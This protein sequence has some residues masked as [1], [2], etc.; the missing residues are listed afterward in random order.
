VI[1]KFSH[2]SIRKQILLGFAPVLLVLG[3]LAYVSYHNGTVFS[4]DFN[5]F[6]KTSQDNVTVL[7]IRKDITEIQRNAL[8]YSY[9]GYAGVL[10]KIEYLQKRLEGKLEKIEHL[11]QHDP[12]IRD[13]LERMMVHY[14][15]YKGEFRGAIR[16]REEIRVLKEEQLK[17]HLKNAIRLLEKAERQHREKG[18]NETAY[19]V[20]RAQAG[21]QTT[22]ASIEIYDRQ[23]DTNLIRE[24]NTDLKNILNRL[25]EEQ[26][27]ETGNVA[28]ALEQLENFLPDF[29]NYV[30]A[31][32]GYSQLANIVLPGKAAEIDKLAQELD[33]LVSRKSESLEQN[34]KKGIS[35]SLNSYLALSVFIACIGIVSSWLVAVSIA[36]PVNSIAKTLSKLAKGKID[37]NIP[38]TDRGDEVG[39][40]AVAAQ[41][42]RNMAMDLE[43]RNKEIEE[44]RNFQTL[45][46]ASIPDYL[47]VKDSDYKIVEA[48]PAFLSLYPPE[49][50]ENIIGTTTVEKFAPE[51]A[52]EFLKYDKKALEE[53]HSETQEH[54]LFPNGNRRVLLTRKTRFENAAQEHFI[55]GIARDITEVHKED[56]ILKELYQITIRSDWNLERKMKAMLLSGLE[57]FDL[58]L[59]IISKI[60]QDKYEVLCVS[61]EDEIKSGDIF[62]LGETYCAYTYQQNQVQ[63]W[64]EA[65]QSEIANHPCYEKFKLE[66]YIGAPLYINDKPYGTINFTQ[67][68]KRRAPFSDREKSFV[69]LMA[70]WVGNE[71]ARNEAEKEL[72]S[73]ARILDNSLNEIYIYDADTLKFLQVN[74]GGVDNIGYSLKELQ[75]MTPVDINPDYTKREFAKLIAPLKKGEREKIVLETRQRRKDGSMYDAE[76]HMQ[77]EKYRKRSVIVS[78]IL[79]VT[80]RKKAREELLEANTE[81]E[82]FAYR[83]SHDLRSPL[84]SALSL[85]RVIKL[86]LEQDD[87]QQ[88]MEG[89]GHV[90]TAMRKLELLVRD[91]LTITKAKNAEQTLQNVNIG[92]VIDESLEKL[93]H[94]DHFERLEIIK[95]IDFHDTLVL[96][97]DRLRLIIENLISNAVKYQD[98]TKDKSF[99][100]ISAYRRDNAFVLQVLDNGLGIPEDKTKDLF[101]MFKRFHPKVSFGSGLGLYMMKKSADILGGE[102]EFEN[103]G[104]GT[105]F[106]FVKELGG[107]A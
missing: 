86:S 30:A 2:L 19:H 24:M 33:E 31:K 58:S 102:M 35:D 10:R 93:S 98:E 71:I 74:R 72:A 14:E 54:V 55:L 69:K 23:P 73:R 65:G 70:Q 92:A 46:F 8:V 29:S 59:G 77:L 99:I 88:A 106:R 104:E 101:T 17:T 82:E 38:G 52:E 78:I 95:K 100:E 3:V 43:Q 81:L 16:K 36:S 45:I 47:F 84:V 50:R 76:I 44:R 53:G 49:E 21:L 4:R 18:D 9:I 61:P 90:E 68:Q 89:I 107:E 96:Q 91:I 25:E 94:M 41:E 6:S 103:P 12:Q 79:D 83:T 60:D 13:R 7:S 40:M 51:D 56:E 57:Y 32:R 48:N 75:A 62:D 5:S 87:T 27:E 105:I 20:A 85:M 1:P 15:D 42:F 64:D 37:E 34:I 26:N 11:A 39:E 28:K 22:R 80:E 66:T 97:E 63:A 67:A